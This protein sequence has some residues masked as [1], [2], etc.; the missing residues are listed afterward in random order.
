MGYVEAG[1]LKT[2]PLG[3]TNMEFHASHFAIEVPLRLS[4]LAYEVAVENIGAI[5]DDI[6]DTD[7]M[8][9]IVISSEL[10]QEQILEILLD[11]LPHGQVALIPAD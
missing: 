7:E 9:A 8:T 2:S 10:G 4:D 6:L 3:A 1:D 11:Y 5:V